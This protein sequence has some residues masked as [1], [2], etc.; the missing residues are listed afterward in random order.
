MV[1]GAM[2]L[3]SALAGCGG[4]KAPAAPGGGAIKLLP[5]RIIPAPRALL[6]ATG[7]QSNGTLW[8]VAGSS[9]LGLFKLNSGTGLQAASM[10]VSRAARSVAQN[11]AGVVAIALGTQT[12]GA[13][14][15]VRNGAPKKTV[16]LPAPAQQVVAASSGTSFYV[17][18][19]WAS[20]ASIS[21]V[22]STGRLLHT[23][24][25]P[26]GSVSIAADPQQRL[27]YVLQRNGVVDEIG[28]HAGNIESSFT[29]D[30]DGMSI[31]VS[32]DGSRLY[33]LKGT[34]SVSNIAVIDTATE[35]VL[36]VLPAPSHCIQLAVAPDGQHLY[37]AVGSPDYGNIQVFGL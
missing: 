4:G 9:S 13:L 17:L 18:T 7:P 33:V 26:A 15:L 16:G 8:A 2:L 11:P 14:E 12:A 30:G 34:L 24:A 25:A 37:E 10:S 1:I 21:T 29:V 20:S 23:V 36:K 5:Q 19:G 6:S 31:A 22:S 35:G 3:T 27:V 32:P 28:V